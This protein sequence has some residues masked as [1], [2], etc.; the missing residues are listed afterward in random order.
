MAKVRAVVETGVTKRCCRCE[1]FK[2]T[3]QFHRAAPRRDGLQSYCRD[4]KRAI[5]KEHNTKNPRRN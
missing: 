5:D 1:A 3:S 4:C 2:D